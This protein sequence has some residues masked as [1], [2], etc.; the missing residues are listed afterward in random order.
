VENYPLH[1]IDELSS[2]ALARKDELLADDLAAWANSGDECA[3]QW[4]RRLKKYGVTK[5]LLADVDRAVRG[6]RVHTFLALDVDFGTFGW[7]QQIIKHR[8]FSD[9]SAVSDRA[10]VFALMIARLV[11]A[12]IIDRLKRCQLKSCRKY[13]FGGPRAKW[14][15]DTCGSKVRVRNKRKRDKQRQ[16]L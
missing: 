11:N 2:Y 8:T 16:M 13:F 1:D 15:S 5:S 9:H 14:C 7:R 4:I 3:L 10:A 12:G 6:F